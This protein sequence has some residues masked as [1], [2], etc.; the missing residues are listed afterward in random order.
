LV[1]GHQ[2]HP[3]ASDGGDRSLHAGRRPGDNIGDVVFVAGEV[4]LVGHSDRAGS[5]DVI[6]GTWS[7]D[8]AMLLTCLG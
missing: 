2:D 5:A 3:A 6:R 4:V 8:I 1:V 7:G